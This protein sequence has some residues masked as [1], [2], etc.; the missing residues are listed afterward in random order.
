MRGTKYKSSS[1]TYWKLYRLVYER[2]TGDKIK[3]QNKPW[4]AYGTRKSYALQQSIRRKEI[5]TNNPI[6]GA[7]CTRNSADHV[8][9]NTFPI[10]EI[11]YDPSLVFSP[12]VILLGIVFDD[13]ALAAPSLTSP[14][15]LSR[16][17]H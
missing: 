12:H 15:N 10:P 5:T 3:D 11:V 7:P 4:H 14:E 13:Q 9:S 1:G 6:L 16:L 17:K 8:S 2:A